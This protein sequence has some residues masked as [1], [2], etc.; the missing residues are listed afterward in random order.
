MEEQS[1]NHDNYVM[2]QPVSDSRNQSPIPDEGS[3][4]G[5]S[6]KEVEVAPKT[7]SGSA[8]TK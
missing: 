5:V 2:D 7:D 6:D 3:D 4:G 8:G 1:F